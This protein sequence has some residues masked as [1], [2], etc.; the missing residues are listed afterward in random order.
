MYL[1]DIAT[2][3]A[4]LVGIPAMSL[5]HSVDENGMPIGVQLLAPSLEEAKMLNF[6]YQLENVINFNSK[7]KNKFN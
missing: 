3:T 2:I 4:N 1:T 7:F 6:A 5:P